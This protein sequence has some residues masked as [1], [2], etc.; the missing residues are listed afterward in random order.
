MNHHLDIV[1]KPICSKSQY[2]TNRV[3]IKSILWNAIW[4]YVL[5]LKA[6]LLL[7]SET[8]LYKSVIRD[9]IKQTEIVQLH[10]TYKII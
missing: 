3:Q 4:S 1:Q 10:L 2:T 7:E 5:S 9:V 6:F 8:L